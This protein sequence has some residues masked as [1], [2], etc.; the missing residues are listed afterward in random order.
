MSVQ[1]QPHSM[2]PEILQRLIEILRHP[3]FSLAVFPPAG[4]D[5][6]VR[7]RPGNLNDTVPKI[8]LEYDIYFERVITS[9]TVSNLINWR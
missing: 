4:E 9:N 8:G 6:P 1:Q 5:E 2:L 3:C 7:R